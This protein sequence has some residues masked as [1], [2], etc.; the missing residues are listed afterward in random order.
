M[1]IGGSSVLEV[2][3]EELL[4][5]GVFEWLFVF[6]RMVRSLRNEGMAARRGGRVGDGVSTQ[7]SAV[8]CN[9]KLNRRR[10]RR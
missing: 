10:S 9:V 1:S 3:P 2:L 6:R 4:V 7:Q 8:R 5:S